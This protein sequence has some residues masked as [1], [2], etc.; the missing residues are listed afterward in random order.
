MS[1]TSSILEQP[2]SPHAFLG[3]VYQ[4]LG[5]EEGALL[6]AVDHPEPGTLEEEE[7]VEKGDWLAL[8]YKVG[9][10]KLFFVKNDSIL[11]FCALMHEP[12]DEQAV[13]EKFRRVW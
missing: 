5:Y 12:Q 2:A 3:E 6:N 7:W 10:E 4:S 13:L 9:A 1:N 11:I 8:A